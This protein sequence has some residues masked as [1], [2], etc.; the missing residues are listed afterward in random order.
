[1]E[2]GII[3]LTDL[4]ITK[5]TNLS[6]KINSLCQAIKNDLSAI[7]K[8]YLVISGD[9]T[10]IGRKEEYENAEKIILKIKTELQISKIIVVPGNHD[11]NFDNDTQLRRNTI[12]TPDYDVLGEDGSIISTSL[13]VQKDF[14]EFYIKLNNLPD[15]KI[16]YQ[17][18]DKFNDKEICFHC[19][20][21]AWMSKKK[22]NPG[23]LFF[24]VNLI[25][26]HKNKYD[27][28][29]SV[30]HH[31]LNWFSPNTQK[32]NKNEFQDFLDNISSLKLIGHEHES[33]LIKRKNLDL[34][35]ETLEFSG[36]IFNNNSA[37]DSG[38]QIIKICINTRKGFI[39]KYEWVNK[40]YS[41]NLEK[42]IN[43]Q[44]L[45]N[46]KLNLKDSFIEYLNDI[47]IPL[48][49]GE[50]DIKL[51]DIYVFPDIE[52]K[53]LDYDS[54][55]SYIDS[56]E[57]ISNNVNNKIILEGESQIGKT[58]LIQ[59]LFQQF[60][61]AGYYPIIL[62]SE[63]INKTDFNK[64]VKMNFG[65]I[66]LD[67]ENNCERFLQLDKKEKVLLI[68][69]IHRIK[70]NSK[71]LEIFIEKAIDL[72]S[73]II[74][75]IDSASGLS[76]D[77]QT[78]FGDF[79]QYSIKQLG[80]KKT[81][82][83]IVK[84]FSLKEDAFSI[85]EQQKLERIKYTFNQVR[86][87]LG[88]KILPSYPIFIL[89]LLKTLDDSAYS[90]K[91]TSY[92]YCYESLLYFALKSKAKL[93][94]ENLSKYLAFL[95]KLAYQ[96]FLNEEI[97]FSEIYF[98][99]FHK[100]YRDKYIIDEYSILKEN[101]INSYII[102]GYDNSYHFGYKY[103]FY[104]LVAKHIS[105]IIKE[106]EGKEIVKNLFSNLHIEENANILV[107]ITHHTKDVEFIQESVLQA[108]EP[109]ESI[110]PITL[111]KDCDYYNLLKDLGKKVSEEIINVDIDPLKKRDEIL[112]AYDKEIKARDELSKNKDIS[113][114]NFDEH[115]IPFIKAFKSIDIVSQIIKNRIGYLTKSEITE[116]L[117]ELYLTGF[118]LIG[119]VGK[120]FLTEKD[121]LT[122]ELISI[123][124]E[125]IKKNAKGREYLLKN[126][127]AIED[128]EKK[129]NQFFQVINL[130]ICLSVFSKLVD[131]LGIKDIETKEL[132]NTVANNINTPASKLVTFSI[133]S[134]HYGVST[135]EIKK[136][137]KELESNPVA[138]RILKARVISYVY[139]NHLDYRKKQTISS[140]LNLKM[141][142]TAKITSDKQ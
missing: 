92:G 131:S 126:P 118:R 134:Y 97:E 3:H 87:L 122:K 53:E 121:E 58:S 67:Y 78:V 117:S 132:Y 76:A 21:T 48:S 19:F 23:N 47:K 73:T 86:S 64:L 66:Y 130:Q 8:R 74:V 77:F 109:F 100:E 11:C 15:D 50:K 35:T 60:Y 111:H 59:M 72:Y 107:F 41:S 36:Q 105:G 63:K 110:K 4:H 108:M 6:D 54:L 70:L 13:G 43:L 114:V 39:K 75:T 29:I 103:I 135:G 88:D 1:M 28:N 129:V 68:D 94:E 2:I 69:D 16:A 17:I 128:I 51:S 119:A 123:I 42:K 62:D 139:N 101:L 137:A 7:N 9:I 34:N 124:L 38:F 44:K 102:K 82:D 127:V 33:K 46:R 52:K 10:N 20:N 49:I 85:S 104:Y 22:E 113:N 30:L 84:Y 71:Q 136:L 26:K 106:D 25:K 112:C 99:E 37:E 32:N 12:S 96:Q 65:E 91:E 116:Y 141:Q 24:P 80:Y 18:I 120:S 83:L 90:L 79:D 93:K 115:M 89:S 31:P 56:E 125:E 5:D 27:L 138:Y 95:E 57:I 14:W 61:Q 133:I 142:P 140:I 55:D 98:K 81:N 45:R 40:I